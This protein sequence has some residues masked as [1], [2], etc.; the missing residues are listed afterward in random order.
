M[1]AGPDG[2]ALSLS[3][4]GNLL[5]WCVVVGQG[6]R[7]ENLG[8]RF[9]RHVSG[10]KVGSCFGDHFKL[11]RPAQQITSY[12]DLVA[13]AGRL[14]VVEAKGL[15][16]PL[17]GTIMQSK[18]QKRCIFEAS[19]LIRSQAELGKAGLAIQD[20]SLHDPLPDLLLALQARDEAIREAEDSSHRQQESRGRLK[21]I[22]DSALDAMITIDLQGKV[23]EF[24]DVASVVFG[25][26][27]DYALGRELSELIIP[28]SLRAQHMAGME[29]FRKTGEGP[30]LRQRIEIQGMRSD[31]SEFPV[32]LAV[33]PF[34]YAD[35]KYFT[36]TL[37]D[38]TVEHAQRA[39]IDEAARQEQLLNR[40]LDHRVKNML[41]QILVLCRHA[42]GNA[43]VDRDVVASLSARVMSFSTVHELLSRERAT[44]IELNELVRVCL[45]PYALLDTASVTI[46][47]PLCRVSPKAAMTLA[48]VLNELATNASKHGALAHQ[49]T[50]QVTW[51]VEGDDEPLFSL[52]WRES[53][54]GEKPEE[55]T[56]GFGLQVLQAV[57][58]HELKGTVSLKML[59]DGLEYTASIPLDQV[60]QED[61]SK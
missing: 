21:S 15:A 9:A 41:A 3:D 7:I 23:V 2:Q 28:P 5:P 31:G 42:E 34:D 48:M 55:L 8:H 59:S 18:D 47:G 29:H 25:Y 35:Q 37:R 30:I 19:P 26:E 22:L 10:I 14:L 45:S 43:T 4:L 54:D 1:S 33:I 20:F 13:I 17:R 11:L 24:N 49:G 58:P 36:A 60:T 44:G 39:A 38:L 32:A 40:E 52:Q 56:G 57:V 6:L 51:T 46:E 27:R 50:L 61:L 53:H 12:D 16:V